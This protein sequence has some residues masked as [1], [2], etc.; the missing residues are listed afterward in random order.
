MQLSLADED[1]KSIV[2]AVV[3]FL[4]SFSFALVLGKNSAALYR[5][6]FYLRWYAVDKLFVE[7]RSLYDQRNG[8]E[9]T[10]EVWGE[11]GSLW[12]EN[13]YY[14]GHLMV[15][16]GP[17][18]LLPYPMA[19]LVWT[20]VGQAFYLLAVWL[21]MRLYGWPDSI[22]RQ[23]VF[24]VAA[25]L[26]IPYLQHTIWSQFNTIGILSLVLCLYALRGHKYG[27][28]GILAVGLTF[29]PHA[30]VLILVFLLS[31][32]LFKRERWRFFVGFGVAAL[33]MWAIAEALQ[34]GWVIGFLSRLGEY[35]PAQSVLDRFWN[36]YQLVAV[37]LC[38][39]ALVILI[40]NRH[41]PVSST[42]FSACITLS[43]GI[44]SLVVPVLGM[45]HMVL[46]PIVVVLLLSSLRTDFP[47][48]YRPALYGVVVLYILGIVGFVWGLSSP[49]L[50]GK[51][52]TWS[53]YAYKVAT[54]IVI[55]LFS[56][57]LALD[58][59]PNRILGR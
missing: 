34:P 26:F 14:P 4:F 21:C 56:L 7:G 49:E 27:L 1:K 54:P 58:A 13:F 11:G 33:V 9:V 41:A 31:W 51:H 28:A 30:T 40:Q 19:H 23:T 39:A 15:L 38:L 45:V 37:G 44:W 5:S 53:Q 48:L 8:E 22:N 16:I 20:F 55:G 47:T 12:T 52:I 25:V 36:P 3:G 2:L 50:Y 24:M 59:K 35:G 18:A 10:A 43:F 17:L 29:K 6:D 32:A 57:P 46:L 42:A